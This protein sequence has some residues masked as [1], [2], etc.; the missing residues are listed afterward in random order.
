MMHYGNLIWDWNS[1]DSVRSVHSALE[2]SALIFFALLVLF[3][4]LAHLSEDTNKDRSKTLER[5]G[6]CC[7]GVAVLAEMLAYPYSKRND[8]LSGNEIHRLSAVAEKARDDANAAIGSAKDAKDISSQAG[9]L[10]RGV[11]QDV[12]SLGTHVASVGRQA[13]TL[14]TKLAEALR[15]AAKEQE[16]RLKIEQELNR[17]AKEQK[18]RK[19]DCKSF[20]ESINGKPKASSVSILY[21][22]EDLEAYGYGISIKICLE[23]AG[24]QIGGDVRPMPNLPGYPPFSPNAPLSVRHGAIGGLSLISGNIWAHQAATGLFGG[25]VPKGQES[26]MDTALGTLHLAFAK[27]GVIAGIEWDVSVP[28]D[29]VVI[30]I[31]PA[32]KL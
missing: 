16:A 4:V 2:G 14:S 5:I 13:R 17:V 25:P 11:R 7:F 26:P 30:V 1:I 31:G 28:A 20:S 6:L 15:D 32:P 23:T 22:P 18:W 9:T 12:N 3:D 19:L 10:A 8:E 29:A 24:W 21:Q 27:E